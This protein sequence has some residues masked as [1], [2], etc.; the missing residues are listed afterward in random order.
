MCMYTYCALQSYAVS[1]YCDSKVSRYGTHLNV[2]AHTLRLEKIPL[3]SAYT[4]IDPL[5][6]H[7]RGRQQ[8]HNN[9]VTVVSIN[10]A[11]EQKPFQQIRLGRENL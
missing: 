6:E 11:C 2:Y 5:E 9:F 3:L 8:W 1:Q 4:L 10:N 7:V